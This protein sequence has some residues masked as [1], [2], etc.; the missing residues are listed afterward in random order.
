MIQ[1]LNGQSTITLTPQHA[2]PTQRSSDLS[3]LPSGVTAAFSPNPTSPTTN[4]STLTLTASSTATTGMVTVTITSTDHRPTL[5]TTMT[6][7][8]HPP[9]PQ[10]NYTLSASPSNVTMNQAG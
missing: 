2:F 5:Q 3:T 1:T 10:Q 4:R 9:P 7:I 8:C 6:L